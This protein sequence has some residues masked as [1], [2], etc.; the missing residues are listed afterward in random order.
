[1]SRENQQLSEKSKR[2]SS[3]RGGVEAISYV[4]GIKD[5]IKRIVTPLDSTGPYTTVRCEGRILNVRTERIK[6]Q[7][8]DLDLQF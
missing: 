2:K 1:M 8:D 6:R 7:A 3:R 4:V 5:G